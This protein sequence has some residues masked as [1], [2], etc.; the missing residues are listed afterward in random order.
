MINQKFINNVLKNNP[1]IAELADLADQLDARAGECFK[2]AEIAKGQ[3]LAAV[4]VRMTDIGIDAQDTCNAIRA[5]VYKM[6]GACDPI[7]V[8][9]IA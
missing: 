6:I 5:K 3:K 9:E 4:V 7:R 1:S 2:L 8:L